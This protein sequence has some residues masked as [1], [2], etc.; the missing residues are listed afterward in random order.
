MVLHSTHAF[1]GIRY[2]ARKFQL[3][4]A[5]NSRGWAAHGVVCCS[6]YERSKIGQDGMDVNGKNIP[7]RMRI[8]ILKSAIIVRFTSFAF[9]LALPV[10]SQ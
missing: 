5:L 8:I 9:D 1:E 7:C 6:E 10:S 3:A 4:T 2:F